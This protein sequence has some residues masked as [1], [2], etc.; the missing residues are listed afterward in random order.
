GIPGNKILKDGDV[1]SID[2]GVNYKG[3]FTDGASTVIVGKGD[4]RSKKLLTVCRKALDLAT[5]RCSAGVHSGDIGHA[6]ESFVEKNGFKVFRELVGH[7]VGRA[8]HESPQLPN[9]GK[10][11]TGEKLKERM[12]LAI[13]PMISEGEAQIFLDK[14]GWTLKTKDGT[15]AA[16][17]EHTVLILKNGCDILTKS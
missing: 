6:V 1:V 2:L 14:D 13:E 15:R 9:W 10:P 5:S 12:V 7:G 16:H 17:F 3:F 8:V 11:G 4:K